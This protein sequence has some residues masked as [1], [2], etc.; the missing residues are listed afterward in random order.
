MQTIHLYRSP[1][2]Y[3]GYTGRSISNRTIGSTLRRTYRC[4]I[5][6]GRLS[7]FWYLFRIPPTIVPQNLTGNLLPS[8]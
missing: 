7:R 8:R 5:V 1:C 4:Q 3:A 2:R 6:R